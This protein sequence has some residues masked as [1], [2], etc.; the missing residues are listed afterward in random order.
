[1]VKVTRMNGIEFVINA[2]LIEF[3]EATP[4]T[5]ITLTTGKKFVLKDSVQEVVDRIIE[6][7]KAIGTKIIYQNSQASDE[8]G[9]T[10]EQ[11]LKICE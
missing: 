5:V 6:Y 1:M 3:I 9:A 2:E 4:D 8:D 7:R 10:K 11:S